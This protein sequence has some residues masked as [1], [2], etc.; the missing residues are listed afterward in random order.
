MMLKN[1][2]GVLVKRNW[3]EEEDHVLVRPRFVQ[4]KTQK[5]LVARSC[6]RTY[7]QVTSLSLSLS[8]SAS[9]WWHA[10]RAR[11]NTSYIYIS[12]IFLNQ[13]SFFF[14]ILINDKMGNE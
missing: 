10:G 1:V 4:M 13:M 3:Q 14:K 12:I 8:L 7:A 11:R 9:S 6:H 2:S 5:N